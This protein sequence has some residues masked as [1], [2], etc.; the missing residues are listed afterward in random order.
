MAE[1]PKTPAQGRRTLRQATLSGAVWSIAATWTEQAIAFLVLAVLAHLLAPADFGAVA[2]ASVFVFLASMIVQQTFNHALIQRRQLRSAHLDSAF[3]M[4]L[5]FGI[6]A[7]LTLYVAAGLVAAFFAEPLVAELLRWLTPVVALSSLAVVPGAC[8]MREMRFDV[9]AVRALA[10]ASIGGVVGISM[11]LAGF[12]AWSLVGQ[13]LA[14]VTSS[15]AAIWLICPWRPSFRFSRRH[16]GEIF[17]FGKFVSGQGAVGFVEDRADVLLVGYFLGAAP[18]GIYNVGVRIL[19]LLLNGVCG[20]FVRVLLPSY[21]QLQQHP[22]R[23]RRAL[24]VSLR[25][26]SLISFA[27]FVGLACVAHEAI[28]VVLGERW[29]QATDVVR[30][31]ALA[32]VLQSVAYVNCA[33]VVACGR[34]DWQ[35]FVALAGAAIN[36]TAVAI[37]VQWGIVA[38]AQALAA[39]SLLREPLTVWLVRKLVPITLGSYS[40]ALAPAAAASAGMAGVLALVRFLLDGSISPYAALPLYVAM[41]AAAYAA[42]LVAITPGVARDVIGIAREVVFREPARSTSP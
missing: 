10:A 6:T 22:E 7:A 42:L 30:F 27:L 8:L 5:A 13:Q 12:G 3:W 26:S 17:A 20:A 14:Y 34:A 40:R 15:A 36:V 23:L 1:E 9:I 35:F 4:A 2:L 41:G 11:A 38:A 31:L 28:Y 16:A 32:G 19:R 39:A 25:F 18:V 33:L 37:G 24:W 21:S 29:L